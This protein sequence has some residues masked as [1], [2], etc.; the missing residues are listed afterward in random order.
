[1]LTHP[2]FKAKLQSKILLGEQQAAQ[3]NLRP[4]AGIQSAAEPA[5]TAHLSL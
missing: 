1:M 5:A 2:T 3:A 4:A